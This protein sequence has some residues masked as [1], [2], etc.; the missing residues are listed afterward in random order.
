MATTTARPAEWLAHSE[1]RQ[2]DRR[3]VGGVDSSSRI[4]DKKNTCEYVEHG[5]VDERD[6]D[7]EQTSAITFPDG[8]L[9]AWATVAGAFCVQF[10]GFGCVHK[11]I[12]ADYY[13]REYLTDYSSSEISCVQSFRYSESVDRIA[14]SRWI[15]S[16]QVF[17]AI[18]GGFFA[19]QLFDRG[20]FKF[21]IYCG[22][23]FISFGLF[24][25]SLAKPN[26]YYQ[27]ILSQGV[28]MGI[29][30][31]LIYV[32]SI[33][34]ISHHFQKKRVLAMSIVACGSSLGA[35]VHP[36]MLNNTLH[37]SLGFGNSVR[38]SAALVTGML[39]ISCC[40]MRTRLP[41]P[42]KV[43]PIVPSLKK[44][45]RDGAYLA[46]SAAFF[47]VTAGFYYT[48]YY[49]QLN[50][51]LHNV[52]RQLAFY[53]LVI[54]NVCQ[55]IGRFITSFLAHR[56][57]VSLVICVAA[58]CCAAIVWGM[59]AIHNIASVVLV[60]VLFGLFGGAYQ[61]LLAP[62]AAILADD[63]SE[64]GIRMGI[65]FAILAVGALIGSPICGA[66]LT[67]RY[68]WWRATLFSSVRPWYKAAD[69]FLLVTN[70]VLHRL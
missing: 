21:S 19:G 43:V 48:L 55:L 51:I 23:F 67:H 2:E 6:L 44:F 60:G 59:V 12:W 5:L 32:P 29:G 58:V 30:A 39:L 57:G 54:L 35:I 41:P 46:T 63:V 18:A 10:C 13:T 68:I 20:H 65:S 38:A 50:A 33:A 34:V 61:A 1:K 45:S 7:P 28:T 22:A 25:L 15:G 26:A 66:L 53:S 70:Y 49:L 42:T 17:L 16:T 40:L 36:I 69:L 62:A 27:C 52:P 8:G 14:R 3:G 37:S 4:A 24:M 64:I 47:F 11:F 31:G 9:Q 56:V